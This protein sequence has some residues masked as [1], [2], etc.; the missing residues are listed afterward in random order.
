MWDIPSLLL[1]P[2]YV[3]LLLFW[4]RYERNWLYCTSWKNKTKW[5]KTCTQFVVI[6]SFIGYLKLATHGTLYNPTSQRDF[7]ALVAIVLYVS[8]ARI[9][10]VCLRGKNQSLL[11]L[12]SSYSVPKIVRLTLY[13][14]IWLTGFVLLQLC[15]LDRNTHLD[16]WLFALFPFIVREWVTLSWE[17]QPRHIAYWPLSA[18]FPAMSPPS[19]AFYPFFLPEYLFLSLTCSL[20]P[21]FQV[22]F[23]FI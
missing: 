20:H 18:S 8:F 11:N 17:D 6:K 9:R 7:H 21:S 12:L 19:C 15:L 22:N 5:N 4:D 13:W 1:E 2:V 14:E 23:S 16:N 3:F 10:L